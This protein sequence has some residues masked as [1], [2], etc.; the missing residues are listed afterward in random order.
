MAKFSVSYY[1]RKRR[2]LYW[3]KVYVG[4]KGMTP[5]WLSNYHIIIPT[6][7]GTS[8]RLLSEVDGGSSFC[9]FTLRHSIPSP[10][11]MERQDMTSEI[12]KHTRSDSL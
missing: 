11:K 1:L 4:L 10:P 7:V 12:W 8:Y 5:Y 9:F 3:I 2:D 6:I